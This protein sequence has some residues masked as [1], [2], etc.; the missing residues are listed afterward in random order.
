MNGQTPGFGL[1]ST[2][3]RLNLI[4]GDNARFEIKQITPSLVEAKV[5]LPVENI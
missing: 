1:S 2:T 4:Y 5:M 3:D